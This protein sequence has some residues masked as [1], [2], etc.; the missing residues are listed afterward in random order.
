MNSYGVRRWEFVF[1]RNVQPYCA[2]HCA[3]HA[4]ICRRYDPPL[5]VMEDDAEPLHV[6]AW[7]EPPAG[8]DR[9][10]LG[11]NRDGIRLARVL[12]YKARHDW[13]A[14]RGFLWRPYNADWFWE[15][16]ML[17]YHACLYLTRRIMD[18]IAEY[19]PLRTGAIDASVAELD[20]YYNVAAPT[21]CWWWQNDGRNGEC[22]RDFVP[23]PL[24]T[25]PT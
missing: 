14:H 22:T 1:G 3:D 18:R 23:T 5:L 15:C 12:G 21:S 24:W 19:V 11:G 25:R 8:C 10:H 16:G 2:T 13:R 17:A 6:R 4:A 20:A 7:I 9:I